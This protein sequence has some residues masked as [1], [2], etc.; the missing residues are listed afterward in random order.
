MGTAITHPAQKRLYAQCAHVLSNP[1]GGQCQGI[2]QVRQAHQVVVALHRVPG[3]REGMFVVVALALFDQE[4]GLDP[5]ALARTEVALLMDVITVEGMAG[6][7]D[8]TGMFVD[9]GGALPI[10]V[11]PGFFTADYMHPWFVPRNFLKKVKLRLL[12]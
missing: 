9:N 11:L 8:M 1:F 4:A 10:D 5:P 12:S 2:E 7:P 6:D 3:I